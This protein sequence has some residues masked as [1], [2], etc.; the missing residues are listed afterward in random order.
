M[1]IVKEKKL[2]YVDTIMDIAKNS[3]D[4]LEKSKT[5]SGLLEKYY[6][7][8]YD[9]NIPNF[10]SEVYDRGF[11]ELEN[12]S[13]IIE[14]EPEVFKVS[15][16]ETMEALKHLEEAMKTGNGI[17]EEEAEILL[18][19]SVQKTRKYLDETSNYS[20]KND[21]LTGA[22]GT[23]QMLTLVP[24]QDIG[25]KATANNTYNF[26]EKVGHH[27]FGTVILP[28][29]ENGN[30]VE[31]QYL[32]DASFRQ[33]FTTARCNYG[34]YYDLERLSGPDPGYYV[35][36]FPNGE[37]IAKEILKRGYTELTNEVLIMY[38]GSFLASRLN[39]DTKDTIDIYDIDLLALKDSIIN[40]QVP[41][42]LNYEREEIQEALKKVGFPSKEN[43]LSK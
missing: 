35:N 30:V 36:K 15:E 9:N 29:E 31:K 21:S 41:V 11:N 34:R 8:C 2:L 24:F 22:C 37:E 39:I 17:T 32:V 4:T 20:I 23:A 27:A 1:D 16:E 6:K 7:Y 18:D 12:Y 13:Y 10:D 14:S 43:K 3:P 26:G 40:V 38:G 19:W 33:F 25:I 28:I 42:E 5:L